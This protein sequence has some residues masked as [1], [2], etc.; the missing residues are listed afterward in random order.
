MLAVEKV[1]NKKG[2]V[3]LG[4]AYCRTIDNASTDSLKTIFEG[5]IS[6]QASVKTDG[7]RIYWILHKDWGI[8]QEKSNKGANFPLLHTHIINVKGWLRGH[9]P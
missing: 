4:R 6:K 7:W 9:P 1:V 8:K 3:K 2:E 5:H